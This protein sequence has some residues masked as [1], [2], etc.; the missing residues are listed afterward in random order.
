MDTLAH[1]LN[2][3]YNKDIQYWQ[4]LADRQ[5]VSD[6]KI[7]ALKCQSPASRSEALFQVLPT[8]D[9][10]LSIATLTYHLKE[11]QMNNVVK[12]LHDLKLDGK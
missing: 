1:W 4:H 5:E 6:D 3:S 2:T 11:L 12:C 9:P 7:S 8:I 10:N